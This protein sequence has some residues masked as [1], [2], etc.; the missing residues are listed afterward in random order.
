M[1]E[2]WA[3]ERA[4]DAELARALIA[5]QFPGMGARVE[6]LGAGFDNSAFLVDGEWVFRF[7]R[8]AVAVPLLEREIQLLPSLAA[9]LPLP[10]PRPERVG[11]PEA[12]FPWPFAG[13]RALPGRTACGAALTDEERAGFAVPLARFLAA[14]HAFPLAEAAA[15]GA[16][17]DEIARA[18]VAVRAPKALTA[19]AA[20]AAA[21]VIDAAAARRLARI[22]EQT[23][24]PP[25]RPPALVHG[26]LYGRHLLVDGARRLAGV[27]DWGDLHLGARA[28]DL[29]VGWS[30]LSPGARE[31]FLREYGAADEADRALARF[32]AVYH[33]ANTARYA[34]AVGDRDLLDESLRVLR[35]PEG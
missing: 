17:G 9:R 33:S 15:A 35:A 22:V 21:G 5:A 29:A 26:D 30:F 2:P 10:I 16:P 34:H 27:I 31:I 20:L 7:P 6:P 4:V 18:D 8:R 11:R 3:A 13:Y 1:T 32:R 25:P 23:A 19:L 12:R 14:L 24:P 28:I